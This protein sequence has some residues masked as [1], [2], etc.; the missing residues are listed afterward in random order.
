VDHTARAAAARPRHRGLARPGLRHWIV[1][2][3]PVLQPI[4]RA[5]R[6]PPDDVE[7]AVPRHPRRVV[8]YGARDL[9]QRLPAVAGGVVRREVTHRRTEDGAVVPGRA[10][11]DGD[12]RPDLPRGRRRDV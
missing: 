11:G 7:E 1:D 12:L 9:L 3:E 5:I 4:R 8:A 2:V 6:A 10:A